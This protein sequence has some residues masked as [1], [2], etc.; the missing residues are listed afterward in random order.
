MHYTQILSNIICSTVEKEIERHS[1][2]ALEIT[3]RARIDYDRE[4][5]YRFVDLLIYRP[6]NYTK[7]YCRSRWDIITSDDLIYE[8]GE[9]FIKA[10]SKG[11]QKGETG[12]A[13]LADHDSGWR[14]DGV[15]RFINS[16]ADVVTGLDSSFTNWY[17]VLDRPDYKLPTRQ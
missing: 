5:G 17:K 1:Y 16:N 7:V 13:L 11:Y 9:S 4:D 14:M 6:T 12:W 10:G 8:D 2:K 3:F 15:E